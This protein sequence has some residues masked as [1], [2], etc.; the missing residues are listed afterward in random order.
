M[1][2]DNGNGGPL[3]DFIVVCFEISKLQNEN[4]DSFEE[5]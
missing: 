1:M 4:E 3:H 5:A 2:L